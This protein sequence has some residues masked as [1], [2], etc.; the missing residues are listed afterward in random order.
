MEKEKLESLLSKEADGELSPEEADA[1]EQAI[2]S[3]AD[4]ARLAASWRRTGKALERLASELGSPSSEARDRVLAG[5]RVAEPTA[6]SHGTPSAFTVRPAAPNDWRALVAAAGIVLALG[7][8]FGVGAAVFAN[9]RPAPAT[10]AVVDIRTLRDALRETRTLMP[11][12]VRWTALCAGQLSLGTSPVPVG[13]ASDFHFVTFTVRRSDRPTPM[14]SQIAV[15]NG[16][17]AVVEWEDDGWW[18]I[19]CI[20]VAD[21][22]DV[23]LSA[24]VSFRPAGSEREVTLS[25]EPTISG[26]G[27]IP[28]VS[29]R[30]GGVA[31]KVYVSVTRTLRPSAEGRTTL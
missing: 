1:L 15:L 25:A 30:I 19:S 13:G 8:G 14:V 26:T 12:R 6:G 20:P 3:D 2:A 21:G 29:S 16:E 5:V 17:E 28:L 9:Q 7:T 18:S 24:R 23:A 11:E 27:S 31:F 22:P 10:E 4:A